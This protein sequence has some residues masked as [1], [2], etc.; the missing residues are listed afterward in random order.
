[1]LQ[2]QNKINSSAKK[3]KK[4]DNGQLEFKEISKKKLC[5]DE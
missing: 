4:K 3:K 2:H 1:M 5:F